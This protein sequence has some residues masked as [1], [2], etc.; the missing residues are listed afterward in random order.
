MRVQKIAADS[1]PAPGPAEEAA[2]APPVRRSAV[3]ERSSGGGRIIAPP[4]P[5]FHRVLLCVAA[6]V[7]VLSCVLRIEDSDTV[8]MPWINHP[9][10]NT[11]TYKRWFGVGCPGCGLTRSFIS[12]AHGDLIA[13]W[14]YNPAGIL[15]FSVALAQLPFRMI[16]LWRIRKGLCEMQLGWLSNALF[17][18]CFGALF[19]QWILRTFVLGT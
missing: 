11:C 17:G 13:A 7:L 4:D 16:Q 15:L 14:N 1:Q 8:V 12:L 5:T 19:I 10:P 3:S 2:E 6:V 18:L 9:L